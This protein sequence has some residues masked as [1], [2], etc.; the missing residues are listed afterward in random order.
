MVG[1][2]SVIWLL[3]KVTDAEC[4]WC[5]KMEVI[6]CSLLGEDAFPLCSW[7]HMEFAPQSRVGVK[8]HIHLPIHLFMHL[9]DSSTQAC[10]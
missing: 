4:L 2:S 3:T 9:A 5:R 8:P 10:K 7:R 6:D 1:V